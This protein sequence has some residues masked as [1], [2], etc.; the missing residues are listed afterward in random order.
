MNLSQIISGGQT[1]VDRGALDAALT[2]Q[3]SCGGY[4]PKGRKAE[5]GVIDERYPLTEL[6]TAGYRQRTIRNLSESDG[7]LILYHGYLS[8]G[9][10]ETMVQC[11]RLHKPYKLIDAQAVNV[12]Y[13]SELALAFI[14]DFDIAVLNVAGPRLSQWADGYQYSLEVIT[15]LIEVSNL[16]K[17][18]G[19]THVNL[20][21]L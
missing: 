5:D 16:L 17:L 12:Q 9:T 10:Q 3:F 11:I 15:N 8:G 21:T 20:A 14:A 4:C 18:S 1:G 19:E 6:S 2:T 13:A 7:T